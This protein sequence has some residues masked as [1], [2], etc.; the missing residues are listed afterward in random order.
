MADTGIHATTSGIRVDVRVFY[1]ADQSRPEQALF[2]WAYKI[3]ITNY[4]PVVV[5]LLRR[6]WKITDALGRVESVHG[7][8]VVG[9]T[10]VLEPGENFEY[11]SGTRLGT[12]SGFMGGLYH[13]VNAESGAEFDVEIPVFSL[14][15]P[16]QAGRLH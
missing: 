15:S 2:V 14:D 10:P 1:L 5:Q 4:S 6:S 13:M 12:P 16:H 7:P 9:E 3:K 8:G 11:T